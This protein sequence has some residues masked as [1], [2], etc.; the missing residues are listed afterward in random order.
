MVANLENRSEKFLSVRL[1]LV[2]VGAFTSFL[3]RGHRF[4]LYKSIEYGIFY[5]HMNP[6]ITK[7]AGFTTFNC[8]AIGDNKAGV[9]LYSVIPH[10]MI[11][12]YQSYDYFPISNLY[13]P[14]MKVKYEKFKLYNVLSKYFRLD[15][16]AAFQGALYEIQPTPKYYKNFYEFEAQ[17]FDTRA[18]IK[19]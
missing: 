13:T 10:E 3:I 7:Y 12:S 6:H 11:H 14:A 8:I 1:S 4:D 9:P 15:Y 19:R 2:T 5:F 18:Y 17:H 16:E